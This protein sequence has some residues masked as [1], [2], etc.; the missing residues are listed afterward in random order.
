M[1]DERLN[2]YLYC[3]SAKINWFFDIVPV[4]LL[5]KQNNKKTTQDPTT[6]PP[7][8][9]KKKMLPKTQQLDLLSP[10]KLNQKHESCLVLL[11]V[12]FF[13]NF[14]VVQIASW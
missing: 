5:K 6:G 2:I 12:S 9:P 4:H 7:P 10:S 1:T 3:F 11:L 13:G 14:V 8:P